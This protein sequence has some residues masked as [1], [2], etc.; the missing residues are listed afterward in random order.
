MYQGGRSDERIT[1]GAWVWYM[2]WSA[3]KC[4]ST[5]NR[6]YSVREFGL[7]IMIHPGA[8][9]D[10]LGGITP[11]DPKDTEFYFHEGDDREKELRGIYTGQPGYNIG[12]GLTVTGLTHF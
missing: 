10:T 8:E 3:A 6:Q 4:Y 7:D 11:H 9:P 5:I 1:L 2:K 12:I